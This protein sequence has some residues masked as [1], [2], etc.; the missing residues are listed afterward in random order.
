MG[1]VVNG[2]GELM[3]VHIFENREPEQLSRSDFLKQ[4]EGKK[5]SEKFQVGSDIQAP[6][7]AEGSA[8]AISSG[9]RRGLLIIE[10]LFRK[11]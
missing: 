6:V 8:Q 10:E 1:I 5:A 3:R 7:G 11:K 4:F 9:V 2:K